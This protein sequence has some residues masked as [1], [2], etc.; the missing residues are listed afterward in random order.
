M[1]PEPFELSRIYSFD[2]RKLLAKER[3]KD[4]LR[5][6]LA[7]DM[8]SVVA[9]R[10]VRAVA[11]RGR[12]CCAWVVWTGWQWPRCWIRYGLELRMDAAGAD[13]PGSYWGESEAGL[14]G[15]VLHARR[16]TPLHS[17][18]HEAAHFICMSPERRAGLRHRCGRR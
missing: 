13:I 18:L 1:A 3:E 10:L 5:E 7:R 14:I 17:V 8:A 2:E 16:D 12:A 9:R 6:A 15:K 11:P 4:I